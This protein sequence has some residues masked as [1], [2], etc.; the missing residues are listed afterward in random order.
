VIVTK[1]Q[2]INAVNMFIENDMLPNAKG[3]YK[4]VLGTAKSA[5]RHKP[6]LLFEYLKKNSFVS[7]LNVIEDDKIDV[8]LL[9]T[10]LTEGLGADEFALEFRLFNKEYAMHFSAT[11]IQT[12][13]R[14]L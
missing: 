7:M 8:D 11:D 4:I 3:N 13:K 9:A 10:I 14:Y 12:I 6:D 2:F 5:L 1:E